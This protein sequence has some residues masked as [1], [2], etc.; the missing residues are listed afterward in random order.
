MIRIAIVEDQ[1]EEQ[2]R[3]Y[4]Y[5]TQFA[6]EHVLTVQIDV[7]DDG[8]SFVD[9]FQSDYDVVYLDVQMTHMD[10]MTTARKIREVDNTV[11]IVFA[12]N[13]SQVAVQGYSVE[14]IDFLLKPISQT[15]FT[16]HFKRIVSKLAVKPDRFIYVKT[17]SKVTKV[18][19]SLIVYIDSQGHDVSIHT[20][21]GIIETTSALKHIESTL[22]PQFFRAHN[23]YIVNLS[24]VERVENNQVIINGEMVPI[25]RPR[26]KEFMSALAQYIGDSLL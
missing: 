14:A 22:S 10:G 8:L 20:I 3:L 19:E 5:I 12:T 26:K 17:G 1:Q 6:R 7:F 24:Y 16:E 18:D 2:Q 15:M 21:D 13:H 4:Q 9:R 11:L 25:S 23:S